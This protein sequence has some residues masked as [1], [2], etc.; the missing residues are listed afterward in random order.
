MNIKIFFIRNLLRFASVGFLILFAITIRPIIGFGAPSAGERAS[1]PAQSWDPGTVG[2]GMASFPGE[3]FSSA[4]LGLDYRYQYLSGGA[5]RSGNWTNWNQDGN[6]PLFYMQNSIDN[7]VVPVFT[8]YMICQATDACYSNE[9]DAVQNHMANVSIMTS[10]WNEL[11]LFFEK[12]AQ[13]PDEPIILHVEPDLWGFV[14]LS[15]SG[16][17]AANYNR[18][19][20]VGGTG[21]AELQGIPDTFSGF[22]QGLF[23]LRAAKG[24]ENVQIAYHLSAWG[25]GDDF[26]LSNPTSAEMVT[27]G[28]RQVAFYRS[29][30]QPFDLIFTD[31]SDRDAGYYQSIGFQDPFW[32]ELDYNNHRT[33][34][35]TVYQATGARFM[36]WQIPF[37]NTLYRTMNNTAYH[38][39][40]NAVETILGESDYAS[41]DAY[42]ASGVIGFLFGQGA[43]GG[44]TTCPCDDAGDGVTSPAP[45]NGNVLEPL[46]ADDDGGYFKSVLKTYVDSG[47]MSLGFRVQPTPLPAGL[48]LNWND[49]G[50]DRYEVWSSE[51][52]VVNYFGSCRTAS[53]C[54][55]ITGLAYEVALPDGVDRL[56]YLVVPVRSD[57]KQDPSDLI[58]ANRLEGLTF[59]AWISR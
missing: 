5:G 23:A 16:D 58:I 32:S 26:T 33:L 40:D 37:G 28:E 59:F 18:P 51:S 1:Q 10:Y 7:G 54:T 50:A 38:Y 34:I 44:I 42:R 21:I 57:V 20:M 30:N 22:A 39:Q 41:M 9:V 36:L 45:I 48:I 31:T 47:K 55:E 12:A 53:N 6:F 13:F 52:A 35:S 19:V 15:S 17:S 8:Y 14:H 46:S 43:G 29:L 25:V 27:Q 2:I 56:Y 49:V 11:A 4:E 24:A 3:G